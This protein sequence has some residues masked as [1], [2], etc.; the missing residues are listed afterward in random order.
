[1]KAFI[2]WLISLTWGGLMTYIGLLGALRI[3]LFN[4]VN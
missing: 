4:E 1:M 3:C 2:Y